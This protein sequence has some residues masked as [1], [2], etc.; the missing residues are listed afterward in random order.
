MSIHVLWFLTFFFF[1]FF[2]LD[3]VSQR[4]LPLFAIADVEKQFRFAVST[5]RTLYSCLSTS[6]LQFDS[7]THRLVIN[8]IS[9]LS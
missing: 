5:S 7:S 3:G 8:S 2:L 6:C 1:F 9:V 4:K